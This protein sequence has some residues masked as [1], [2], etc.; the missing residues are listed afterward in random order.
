MTCPYLMILSL[1]TLLIWRID[2]HCDSRPSSLSLRDWDLGLEM[3]SLSN[4]SQQQHFRRNRRE[5]RY[6]R[7]KTVKRFFPRKSE[8]EL[9]LVLLENFFPYATWPYLFRCPFLPD[10]TTSPNPAWGSVRAGS[11]SV[12][13][14]KNSD[15]LRQSLQSWFAPSHPPSPCLL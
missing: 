1:F 13:S 12:E 4:Q 8:V 10:F 2:L 15:W 9:F 11:V 14:C 7:E 5:P 6:V 3:K